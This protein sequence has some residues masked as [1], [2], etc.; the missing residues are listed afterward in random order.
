MFV[1]ETNDSICLIGGTVMAVQSKFILSFSLSLYYLKFKLT[2]V[3][4]DIGIELY[5]CV[6]ASNDCFCHDYQIW[7]GTFVQYKFVPD[8]YPGSEH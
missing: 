5:Q 1:S 6:C 4:D 3:S 2:V 7:F 8:G